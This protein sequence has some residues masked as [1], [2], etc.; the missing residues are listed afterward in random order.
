MTRQSEILLTL[1]AVLCVL[2]LGI[3]IL[4]WGIDTGYVLH[5]WIIAIAA[6]WGAMYLINRLTDPSPD[7]P[8]EYK[9][10]VI[11]WGVLACFVWGVIG[12][13][14]GDLLAWQLAF[15]SLNGDMSWSNFG[16]IRPIHTTSVIF[17][18][19]GNALLATSFYVVQR[20]SRA[21][22]SSE[23]LPWL[24]F[25]GY[26]LFVVLAVTG[27]P[28]GITQS[29][30][31]AEPEWYADLILLFTWVAYLLLYMR[32]LARRAEPHI[33]V[34]NW[35]YLGFIV[36][37]AMLHVVNNLSVPVSISYAKS[38]PLFAGVQ[39]AMTQWWYGH[40]AVGFLLTAGFLGMMYYFLP[41]AVGRP[42]YSYRMSILGFWGITFLY[43]WAGS[44]HLHYTALPDWV[45]YLGM[46]MSIILLVPSWGSVF[47]GILTLNG[48]W[49]KVRTDPA[50]RFMMVAVLFYGL[51]TFEGSFMA[52]RPVNTL[53]HYTDWTVGHVHAGALGWVA[54]ITFGAMYKMV[55]WLWKRESMYSL[56]LEAWHFWLALT[57]TLIYVGAMWNSGITQSLMWQTYDPNGAFTYAFIDTVDAMRP[58]Y[59]ARAIG[60]LLYLIGALIGSY[61]IYMTVAGPRLRGAD[62]LA[63]PL[64][65]PAE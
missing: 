4:G 51:T 52:I 6:G 16:R 18:F 65:R 10:D 23:T 48:A 21:R 55:P 47:N 13:T 50:V 64:A 8:L 63:L 44:H 2:V 19:G 34:A 58:Y 54:F 62:K 53:S 57:G 43:L 29:K 28:L 49:D 12:F 1:T 27:Y 9:D 45:Q 24:V 17:G 25:G 15:P 30:E 37:I 11:K 26:N 41:K 56:R 46:T 59:I 3:A 61:N 5:G 60:G 22:L 40:N 7:I 33:Y 38:Y 32:T 20:T 39:D 35:Y 36:V 31:Y 42:I 14:I